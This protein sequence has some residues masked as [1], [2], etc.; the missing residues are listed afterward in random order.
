MAA[1]LVDRHVTEGRGDLP[2]LRLRDRTVTFSELQSQ[3]NSAGNALCAHGVMP[4][5]RV[6]ILLPDGPEFVAAFIGAMK[7]G[8]VPVPLNTAFLPIILA[9]HP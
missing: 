9:R 4:E 7:I 8:A 1:P 3:V 6:A 5:Q 2:A